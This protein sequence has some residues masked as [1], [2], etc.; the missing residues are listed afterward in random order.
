[1]KQ[2]DRCTSL[3]KLPFEINMSG[4][5]IACIFPNSCSWLGAKQPSTSEFLRKVNRANKANFIDERVHGWYLVTSLSIGD[6]DNNVQLL[7]CSISLKCYHDASVWMYSWRG[8]V[9]W[10]LKL[11]TKVLEIDYSVPEQVIR[12][13]RP[14]KQA[15]NGFTERFKFGILTYTY[16]ELQI[17]ERCVPANFHSRSKDFIRTSCVC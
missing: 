6:L 12:R 2:T 13:N 10:L 5:P 1:M 7:T 14:S 4:S 15:C 9:N 16:L 3:L 17:A 8:N 11:F